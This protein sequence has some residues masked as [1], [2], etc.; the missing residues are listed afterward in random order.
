[1]S[2]VGSNHEPRAAYIHVP[3]CAHRCGYC[4]F[5]LVAGRDD[6]IEDYL[7]AMA[8]QLATL[9]H[10]R[11]VET[12][13]IGGGT[14]THLSH[15][16]LND[17]IV[18]LREWFLLVD[19]YEFS[20]EANP[21]DLDDAKIDLLSQLGVNRV[22]LG[23]QSFD[24]DVLKILERDHTGKQIDDVVSYLSPRIPN[25][26][27]DL[28][29]GVPG[30]TTDL[31]KQTLGHAIDLKPA[32][33][34][35]YGLTF[36]KGTSF[37]GRQ[38]KGELLPPSDERQR[39]M[40]GDAMDLLAD[41]RYEQ[42]EISNFARPGFR[43]RHN[44]VYWR[45][46]PYFG[47]GPG[48]AS[49]IDHRRELNHR[50]VTSWLRRVLEGESP[51]GESEQL[52]PEDRARELIILALRRVQGIDREQFRKST[53]LQLDDFAGTTVRRHVDSGLLEDNGQTVRLTRS[54]RFLADSVV[55]DFL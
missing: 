55:V 27:L 14:P 19:D 21:Y 47:F 23:A 46:L 3:F 41:A 13:F 40:Y 7:Q 15:D 26:S 25:V 24:A 2:T 10:P 29:F 4:D 35:T 6:L 9:G 22:S 37:W 33:I 51:L 11:S 34:S 30:Q 28:I 20:I 39:T 17:L 44:E 49:Y 12:L 18:M 16:Q 53:G 54:G 45:G 52:P 50:S 5:T 36:E 48:A 38:L 8:M 42:Y 1:M 31:W 43:C 32:H